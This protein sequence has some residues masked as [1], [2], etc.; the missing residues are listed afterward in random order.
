FV[1]PASQ[2]LILNLRMAIY[3]ENGDPAGLVGGGPFLSGLNKILDASQSSEDDVRGEYAILDSV[4][5]IYIYHTNND[6]IIQPAE[7]EAMLEVIASVNGGSEKGVTYTSDSIIAY[8]YIPELNFIVVAEKLTAD[9]LKDSY[10]VSTILI[11]LLAVTELIILIATVAVSR[12][13]TNP[14]NKVTAAVNS[15]GTLSLK[16]DD[17]VGKY[18]DSKSEVGEIAQ[19]VNSLTEIWQDIISTL[20]ECSEALGSGSQIMVNTVSS[21]S[22]CAV[23]NKKTTQQLSSGVTSSNRAIQKVNADISKINS[24]MN[25]SRTSNDQRISSANEMIHNSDKMF[26]SIVEKTEKTEGDI[27]TSMNYLNALTSINENVKIIQDIAGQTHLLAIN[28]SIEAS[29]AGAAGRGFAVVAAE[30][31]NLSAN[32]SNAANA[33][34]CVCDEM[35]NNIANIKKCLSE[36]ITF[37]KKDVA[38]VFDNMRSIADKLKGSMDE[39]NVDMDKMAEII[40]NI[41][42][43][44]E[45]LDVIVEKNEQGTG[46]ISES[47]QITYSMVKKLEG[48]ISK[49]METTRNIN[50]I[51]S[52]FK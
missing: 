15:L 24:I 28:A 10:A 11:V 12:I 16:K 44:T 25:E 46:S 42:E 4:N 35:D 7:D 20:S 43:E 27:N 52:R 26:T 32:S 47:A 22:N 45:Q 48:L 14:L 50:E 3:D 39:I 33:I 36:I 30:I 41:Q 21:L 9:L 18:A 13:I 5:S 8:E 6:L 37:L 38:S 31:K 23:E 51:I 1:S 40:A 17:E 19:S 2:K 29:R 49:N 34:S